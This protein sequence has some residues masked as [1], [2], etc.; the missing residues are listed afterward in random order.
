MKH[1]QTNSK[2]PRVNRPSS[3]ECDLVWCR[4]RPLQL[5]QIN[6]PRCSSAHDTSWT[7]DTSTTALKYDVRH[8]TNES[9]GASIAGVQV[10]YHLHR[11][12]TREIKCLPLRQLASKTKRIRQRSPPSTFL[13]CATERRRNLS[14]SSTSWNE[15]ALLMFA[16]IEKYNSFHSDCSPINASILRYAFSE[17]PLV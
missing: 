13:V 6:K 9:Q 7:D 12:C 2:T 5:I 17:K 8:Q 10:L 3:T 11:R 4:S 15:C 14:K 16:H 1:I